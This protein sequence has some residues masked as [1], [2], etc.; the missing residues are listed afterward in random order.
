MLTNIE[1]EEKITVVA[2]KVPKLKSSGDDSTERFTNLNLD[3]CNEIKTTLGFN[4][5]HVVKC[6]GFYLNAGHSYPHLVIEF[7][8]HGSLENLLD[9]SSDSL[10]LVSTIVHT[11]KLRAVDQST[12]QFLTIY[13]VRCFFSF[14]DLLTYLNMH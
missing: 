1:D 8:D 7:M 9:K 5:E 10:S 12:I 6:L 14:N 13:D 11:V 4:H 2:V 3:F